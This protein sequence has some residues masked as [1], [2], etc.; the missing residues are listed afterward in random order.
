MKFG[1][2]N[3]FAAHPRGAS[4][5]QQRSGTAV[6]A[7]DDTTRK[8]RTA[9]AVTP[10][11]CEL[12]GRLRRGPQ[13]FLLTIKQNDRS[14]RCSGLG[15]GFRCNEICD[16]QLCHEPLTIVELNEAATRRASRC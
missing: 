11:S 3:G 13:Y 2:S 16:T 1:P 4:T 5:R 14:R 15:S 8:E 12:G 7:T 10:C 6:A 9:T